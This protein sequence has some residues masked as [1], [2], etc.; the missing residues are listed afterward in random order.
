MDFPILSTQ[1]FYTKEYE[2]INRVDPTWESG[3]WQESEQY[4]TH[5]LG[6]VLGEGKGRTALDCSCGTGNQSIALAKLGWR[7][8]ATDF[9]EAYMSTARQRAAAQSLRINFKACDMR[10]L[11]GLFHSEF[12][13]V[14]TCY[15]LDN[16]TEDEG[17]QQAIQGMYA[18]LKP[19]GKCYIRLRDLE[20]LV[21]IRNR[22]EFKEERP[23]PYGKVLYMEDWIYEGETHVVHIDVYWGRINARKAIRG[24][25]RFS[26]TGVGCC[27]RWSWRH[28]Y[29]RQDSI[30]SNSCPSPVPGIRL[31]WWLR[32]SDKNLTLLVRGKLAGRISLPGDECRIC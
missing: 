23:L 24:S 10:R 18:A 11:G 9:T 7:V 30:R 17:I 1:E 19:G 5:Q 4:E 31:R 29:G 26:L 8:T 6:D 16:I 28:F 20:H 13:Q 2:F 22:Y 32:K 15:A 21:H 3:G 14:I 27:V 12:D 25:A